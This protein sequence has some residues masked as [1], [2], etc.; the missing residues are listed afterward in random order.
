MD[1]SVCEG[2]F[3]DGIDTI[4][5][6]HANKDQREACRFF[7]GECPMLDF[8]RGPS[9]IQRYGVE[10]ARNVVSDRTIVDE[11]LKSFE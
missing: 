3:A 11:E 4:S 9:C 1:G 7:P 2:D 10:V 6:A 5:E 8:Q